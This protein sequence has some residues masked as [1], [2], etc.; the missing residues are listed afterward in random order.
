MRIPVINSEGGESV[1]IGRT[2]DE[3]KMQILSKYS[4]DIM[5]SSEVGVINED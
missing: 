5:K 3:C 4:E 1:V 2:Y